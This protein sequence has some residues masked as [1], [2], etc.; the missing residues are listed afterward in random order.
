MNNQHEYSN[1]YISAYIDG[2]LDSDERARLLFD[3]QKNAELAQRICEARIL[4]EKVQL[5][6]TSFA[7]AENVKPFACTTFVSQ[8]RALV[9]SFI[10]TAVIAVALFSRSYSEQDLERTN[11]MIA[12]AEP[13]AAEDL[14]SVV[15]QRE[16]VV[17]HVSRYQ[18]EHFDNIIDNLEGLLTDSRHRNLSIEVV[19]NKSGIKALDADKSVHAGRINQMANQYQGLNIVVCAKSLARLA[20]DG[21]AV[22]LIDA[23]MM[24]PSAA[25]QIAKRTSE[26][27]FYIKI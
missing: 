18:P 4:K 16:K 21:D 23:I 11:N 2:E 20:S 13:V 8:H 5:A 6:Y 22:K 7:Q 9:A 17:V 12:S 19:A 25:L 26:G 24:S 3:E 27:W 14:A 10:I 1:E 15:G